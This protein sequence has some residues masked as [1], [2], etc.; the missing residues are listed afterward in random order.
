[1]FPALDHLILAI[2]D[3]AA[4]A[5]PFE[6]LG[7]TLTPRTAHAGLG[8]ANRAAFIG[9]GPGNFAFIELLAVEQPDL[10]PPSRAHHRAAAGAGGALAS[11]ALRVPD[12]DAALQPL[13]PAA[14]VDVAEVRADDR[15]LLVRSAVI[16]LPAIPCPV[17]LV[18]YPETPEA[19]FQRSRS[20]GRFDHAF[21]LAAL[22]HIAL[23][24][25][26]L[27]AATRDAALLGL[28]PVGEVTT[29]D[30]IIRQLAAG[31]ATVELLAPARQG[32]P[33]AG[34]PPGL[35]PVAACRA[36]VP[37]AGAAR[38]ARER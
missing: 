14:Q 1:M 35:L 32:S 33:L 19:R 4:A 7:L 10:L 17:A 18:Q 36:A 34:R 21:P 12:L 15:R 26:D 28:Q 11:F 9:S 38:L 29:P 30:V 3:L 24:V 25:T 31:A 6:Q 2:P 16:R 37:L 5:A 20:L 27:A 23:L 8:T 22:D 13:R